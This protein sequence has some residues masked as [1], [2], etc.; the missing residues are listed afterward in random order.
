MNILL[1]PF[2]FVTRFLWQT[3]FLALAQVWANKTRSML[4]AL[5]I[6]IGVVGVTVVAA[7]LDGMQ[8]YV[9]TQ[10]EGIGAKKMW[11]NGNVPQ[12][13][14]ST[15]SWTD[16]KI[17]KYEANLLIQSSENIEELTPSSRT[18]WPVTYGK[19]TAQSA[20]VVGI[21][22]SW[23]EIED[24]HVLFGRPFSRIDE[25]ER[26]QVC[27]INELG[28]EELNLDIDPTGDYV[29]IQGRRFLIVGVVET[30]EASMF[31]GGQS[32][33]E[34]FIPFSTHKMMNPYTWT[35]CTLQ[36]K[37][38]NLAEDAKAEIRFILRNHR[39]LG[40][41]DEDTFDMF[42]LQSAIDNFNG[43][44]RVIGIV[45]GVVVGISL[46]VGGIGIMNI[47]LVSVSERTRE[48]GL[49]KAMGAKPP[50]VL[51]QFLVEATVL[52]LIGGLVG[53]TLGF[54]FVKLVG[55]V[56]NFPLES[57]AIPMWAIILSLG[58]SSIVG[59]VFGMGP[60][61]KASRLNPI[62]ALRHE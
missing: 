56:P 2:I 16:V 30:K 48:I 17:T 41:E 43:V 31:E 37:D 13:K 29:L 3:V 33:A 60:A 20:R 61:I 26:R 49:R 45:M 23:H 40:P 62:D 21:W 53:I 7:G 42:A 18:S 55:F 36:L 14:R 28:I 4:T 38:P 39:Q 58:F 9:L 19:I 44:A 25:D 54:L 35:Q 22:P 5:G 24:R 6:I 47:M 11:L 8:G 12:S 59:L 51:L 50:I 46:V 15:M 34:L 52:C 27:L 10:F 57:I 32:R 1:A